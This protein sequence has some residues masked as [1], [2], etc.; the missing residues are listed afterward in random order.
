MSVGEEKTVTIPSEEAYGSWDEERVL[1]LPRDMVP[2]EVAV[3]GQSLYQ[4]QGVVISVDDEAV[5]IDQNH[6]LAG[7]DLTFTITLVEIL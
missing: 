6:H 3:V 2:D 5:V 1:V 7:E 4:P